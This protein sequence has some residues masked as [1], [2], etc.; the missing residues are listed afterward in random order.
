MGGTVGAILRGFGGFCFPGLAVTEQT[1][2]RRF[3]TQLFF[4]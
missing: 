3:G 2:S 4:D 1:L